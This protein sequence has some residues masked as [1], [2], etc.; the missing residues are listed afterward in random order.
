[1][2]STQKDNYQTVFKKQT[3]GLTGGVGDL[4]PTDWTQC[5]SFVM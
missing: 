1:M 3:I 2:P 4:V 5:G